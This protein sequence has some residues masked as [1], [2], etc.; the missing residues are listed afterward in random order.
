ML[1]Y[2]LFSFRSAILSTLNQF[3][4]QDWRR[5]SCKT[6]YSKAR[7]IIMIMALVKR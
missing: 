1:D 5:K 2:D 7:A 4:S 3:V 6:S